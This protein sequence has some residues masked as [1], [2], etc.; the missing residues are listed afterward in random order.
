M[1]KFKCMAIMMGA[2]FFVASVIG[3][4]APPAAQADDITRISVGGSGPGATAYIL[5]GGLAELM[6]T[7]INNP[8]LRLT[9]E[10]T[11]G[12]VA[13]SRLVD[14]GQMD[15]GMNSA[16]LLYAHERGESPFKKKATNLRVDIP[17]GV[18]AHQWATF[19]SSGIRTIKDLAGKRVSIGPRGSSTAVQS[20]RIL[21]AYGVWDK[22]KVNRL[23]WDEAAHAMQDG[24]LD[25]YGVTSTLPTPCI[26]ENA[27]QGEL[28]LIPMDMDVIQKLE[29]EYPGYSPFDLKAGTYEG[30][31]K[32]VLC[33]G[34]H[35]YLIANKNVPPWVVY[36]INKAL[37]DPKWRP[38]LMNLPTKGYAALDFAPDLKNLEVVGMPLHAGNV[39]YWVDKGVK[40]P[41]NLI[42]PEY[43][44]YYKK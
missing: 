2:A 33:L 36:D 11:R 44:T 38:F 9:A 40:I 1:S 22:V 27:A 34:Y 18:S 37:L 15:M 39:K 24:K 3:F 7:K 13:N 8:K 4:A 5:A 23:R 43:Y 10:T 32:D 14:S 30:Q 26:V 16:P 29:K 21:K 35:F 31:K 19:K 28:Y 20:E 17:C 25:A 6:N 12:F 41:K 42:P